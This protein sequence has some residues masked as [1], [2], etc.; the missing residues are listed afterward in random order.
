MSRASCI[1]HPENERLIL[2]RKWQLEAC[3]Q[4]ACA[5]ALLNLFEYWHNIKLEQNSQAKG[6]NDVAKR[7]G[8]DGSQI[9]TLLQ[10]HKTEQLEDAL[11][12]I[13]NKRR[14]HGAIEVLE[15]LKFVSVHRNPNPRYAFDK[16]RHF[17]FH[18]NEV[19]AWLNDYSLKNNKLVS[20]PSSNIEHSGVTELDSSLIDVSMKQNEMIDSDDLYLSRSTN[21]TYDD[22]KNSLPTEQINPIVRANCTQQ[23]TKNT[24]QDYLPK[25]PIQTHTRVAC[26]AEKDSSIAFDIFWNKWVSSTKKPINKNKSC[27]IF[28]SLVRHAEDP[29]LSKILQALE[30]QMQEKELRQRLNLFTPQWPNPSTWLKESRW[31]DEVYLDEEFFKAEILRSNSGLTQNKQTIK[32]QRE[33]YLDGHYKSRF[34]RSQDE[35]SGSIASRQDAIRQ[36][37]QEFRNRRRT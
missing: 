28:S 3:G 12:N 25:L 8:D 2:I 14:I 15:K 18:P 31:E 5:A 9:E 19:R 35:Q 1:S 27:V 29:L 6:F 33:Y 20:D 17:L 4:D 21:R 32:Q 30:M 22:D 24:Y 7:H 23:Y 13:F 10:W 16:T 34:A 26:V 36:F 37:D 11:L